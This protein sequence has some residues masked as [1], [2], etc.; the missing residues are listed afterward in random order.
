MTRFRA[1]LASLLLLS[2]SACGSSGDGSNTQPIE[3]LY[4]VSGGPNLTFE[5]VDAADPACGSTGTG[6]QGFN[7]D[8]QFG[9]RV[10]RTPYLFVLENARQPIRAV[11]RNTSLL[12]IEVDMFLG[13]VQ[14]VSGGDTGLIQPGTCATIESAPFGTTVPDVRGPQLQV[15]V[16][17]P[18]V[19][20]DPED[21]TSAMPDLTLPCA[22]ST[23]DANIGFF[24]TTGDIA[25]S[26]LTNCIL[27][28]FLDA[29]RSPATFFWERP[30]DVY[31]AVMTVNSGQNPEGQP[32]AR[33]RSEL[34]I[35]GTREDVSIG[36]ETIVEKDF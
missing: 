20:A 10:F 26:V 12:P 28:P 30:K 27:Q 8:H 9:D 16:C 32:R 36:G 25:A 35:N 15:D 21:P 19:L 31:A 5:F 22:D 2:L 14:V 29:C 4:Y 18:L 34:F 11:I 1:A 13:A 17:S 24:A 3:V 33:L 6:I 7:L 23:L